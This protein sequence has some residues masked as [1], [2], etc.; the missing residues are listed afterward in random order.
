MDT[1]MNIRQLRLEKGWSQTQLAEL[2]GLSLRTVQRIEKGNKPT[3]E[4]LKALASVFETQWSDLVSARELSHID[5]SKLSNEERLDLEHIREVKRFLRDCAI[6]LVSLP[7]MLIFGWLYSSAS[8]AV[9]AAVIWGSC[10]AW[11][12][13]DVFDAKDFFGLGWEKRMLEKRLGRKVD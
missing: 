12:A 9:A 5:E 10:L 6:Y 11:D 7:F 1:I 3:V 4:S 2:S 8:F 13:F